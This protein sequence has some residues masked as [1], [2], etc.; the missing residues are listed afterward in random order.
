MS[1][2]LRSILMI[3][4]VMAAA[5]FL[6][7]SRSRAPENTA[8]P[9]QAAYVGTQPDQV[10]VTAIA[11]EP[12]TVTRI[13]FT[14]DGQFML[15]GTLTGDIFVYRRSGETWTKQAEPLVSVA[16]AFPGF[17]PEENGLTGL[18]FGADYADA[19]GGDLFITYAYLA[20]END[21]KNRVAR[22]AV[23]PQAG[24]LVGSNLVDI[25]E[26]NASGGSSHQIQ[27]IVGIMVEGQPHALFLIGE[28]FVHQRAQDLSQ[29]AGK[30]MLIGRDGANPL[31]PRPYT[32]QPKL[33][34]IGIRNAPDLAI[35]S[36]D[37]LKRLAI[38]DTGPD[39]YDRFLYGK[40]IDLVNG[41]RVDGIDLGWNG[42][43]DSLLASRFDP[44]ISGSPDPTLYRWDPTQTA[45]NIVFHPGKGVIPKSTEE[46]ASVLVSLF[47][48]TGEMGP[49]V[50]GR[51]IWLATL[52]LGNAPKLGAWQPLV[53]RS[54]TGVN[55]FG[56]PLGL[57]RDP[58]TNDL[59][60]SNLQL[61]T[62]ESPESVVY[63]VSIKD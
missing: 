63:W 44:N 28:G 59:V 36:F 35:N 43:V 30:L 50:P 39:Q 46:Q 11:K 21:I 6:R 54:E 32:S 12:G 61:T 51:A 45:T 8:L 10:D 3:A 48:R 34:A 58:V 60:F 47:G 40:F 62:E 56:H 2:T 55:E 49:E 9:T 33:Q 18:A 4:V 26:A 5:Y 27:G 57:E 41:T 23:T 17:P 53:V 29:E 19:T 38:V 20:G 1:T 15:V 22:L 7:P 42:T 14:P 16:T 13:K 25:F 24:K 52:T 31:G 37:P